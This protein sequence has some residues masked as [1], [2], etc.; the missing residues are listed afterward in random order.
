M[1]KYHKFDGI[2]DQPEDAFRPV[3]G[4]MR[5]HGGGGGGDTTTTTSNVPKEV[6]PTY[7]GLVKKAD[8]ISNRPYVAY[9]GERVAGLNPLQQQA[10][11]GAAGFQ[12]PGQ[13]DAAT[14]AATRAGGAIGTSKFTDPGV[15]GSYM[16]P[17][18][19]QVVNRQVRDANRDFDK[20]FMNAN[21]QNIVKGGLGGYR[22]QISRSVMQRDQGERLDDIRARGYG[23]AYDNASRVFTSDAGRQ[24]DAD[25]ASAGAAD[26]SARALAGIGQASVNAQ[27]QIIGTQAEQGGV[28]QTQNQKELDT[29]YSDFLNQRDWDWGQLT[30]LRNIISGANLGSTSSTSSSSGNPL[31]QA[32]GAGLSALAAYKLFSGGG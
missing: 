30:N 27:G 8:D 24:L 17:Y 21:A 9:E 2:A 16:N 22:D 3:A 26:S 13:F 18:V 28:Q 10:I 25:R 11:D 29:G 1:S 20:S 6:I 15:A 31:A 5:L 7:K 14:E 19:E 4:R 32:G 23:A 12:L